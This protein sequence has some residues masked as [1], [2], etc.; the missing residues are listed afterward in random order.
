MRND[1]GGETKFLEFD[2]D[3]AYATAIF[4]Y[5]LVTRQTT[6]YIDKAITP[7]TTPFQGV[8]MQYGAASTLTRHSV[9]VSDDAVFEAQCS[10]AFAFIDGGLNANVLMTAG[11]TVTKM[12]AQAIN[13]ASFAVTSTLD[14]KID[15]LVPAVGMEYGNYAR[16]LCRI[17]RHQRTSGTAGI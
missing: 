3:P 12:S 13:S 17:N 15:E 10:L 2:K 4:R 9:A 11:D 5:D 16:V 6:G 7:G 14:V 1:S 8:A